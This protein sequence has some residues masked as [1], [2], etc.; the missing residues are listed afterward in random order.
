VQFEKKKGSTQLA[1]I[2]IAIVWEDLI[3]FAARMLQKCQYIPTNSA[4]R[5][6]PQRW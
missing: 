3:V 1:A 6:Y 5:V 2:H 4:R